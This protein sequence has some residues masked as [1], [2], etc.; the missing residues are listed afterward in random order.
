MVYFLV[1]AYP[2]CPG[3]KAVKHMCECILLCSVSYISLVQLHT[4]LLLWQ[5]FSNFLPTV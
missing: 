3:K 5:N 4:L 2:G 1:P